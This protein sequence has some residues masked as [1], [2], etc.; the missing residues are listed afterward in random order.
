M[1][2]R[3]VLGFSESFFLPNLS[4]IQCGFRSLKHLQQRTELD[5]STVLRG[6][7]IRRQAAQIGQPS[8][9]IGSHDT[10]I[11]N[12]PSR[13]R[14]PHANV[15]A[16]EMSAVDCLGP[17]CTCH[18]ILLLLLRLLRLLLLLLL[19]H[20]SATHSSRHTTAADLIEARKVLALPKPRSSGVL[21]LCIVHQC[22]E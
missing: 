13:V 11:R 6:I 12:D 3:A 4:L 9:R 22:I 8:P 5:R 2:V 16:G 10:P 21:E 18:N 20:R 17:F 19:L 15:W 1:V 7:R 14:S